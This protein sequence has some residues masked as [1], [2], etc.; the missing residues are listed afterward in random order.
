MP[1]NTSKIDRSTRWGNPFRV[2]HAAVHPLTRRVVQVKDIKMA[3]S[4]FELHLQTSQGVLLSEA[5]RKELIGRNLACWCKR[6][7]TCH[8]DILLRIANTPTQLIRV[9]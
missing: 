4:L 5:V 6:G 7:Q 1:P 3:V 8:G 2:G 9:A